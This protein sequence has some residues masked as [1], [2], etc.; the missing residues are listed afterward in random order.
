MPI[1]Q[2]LSVTVPG[3]SITPGSN[4]SELSLLNNNLEN[5]NL[6]ESLSYL[7]RSRECYRLQ[8]QAWNS[9][10]KC[11][12]RLLIE[13]SKD[14]TPYNYVQKFPGLQNDDGY[15]LVYIYLLIRYEM[16]AF[17]NWI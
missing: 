3:T 10:F 16:A 14:N 6:D 15:K 5:E 12:R 4:F 13:Y 11:R 2:C 8:Q 7:K 17:N 9:T 1:K